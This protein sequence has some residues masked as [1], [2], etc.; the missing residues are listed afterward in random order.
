MS[1]DEIINR[2]EIRDAEKEDSKYFNAFHQLQKLIN[3]KDRQQ[4]KEKESIESSSHIEIGHL[5]EENADLITNLNNQ[6]L[7]NEK[8]E[9]I[10]KQHEK[11]INQLEKDNEKLLNKIDNLNL[12]IKEKNKTIE[13]INDEVLTSNIQI[14]VL[15]KQLKEKI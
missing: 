1:W 15:Q 9:N 8:L 7:I 3:N 12:E 2:L 6:T 4:D 11:R 10:I 13:L 5:K 14:T